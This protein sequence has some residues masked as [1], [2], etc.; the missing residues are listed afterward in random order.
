MSNILDTIAEYACCRTEQAKKNISTLDMRRL[1]E[2]K[3][4]IGFLLP[5]MSKEELFPTVIKDGALPRK[6]FSMGH[7]EDK[8]FYA[9]CRKITE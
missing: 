9:E 5:D 8:R 1:A 7:A 2:D 6:T 3:N 4:S